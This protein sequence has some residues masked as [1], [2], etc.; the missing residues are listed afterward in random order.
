M[1][2]VIEN[3][4]FYDPEPEVENFPGLEKYLQISTQ[5]WKRKRVPFWVSFCK[6]FSRPGKFSTFGQGVIKRAF[7]ITRDINSYFVVCLFFVF[8]ILFSREVIILEPFLT[9][10]SLLRTLEIAMRVLIFIGLFLIQQVYLVE[11]KVTSQC[12]NPIW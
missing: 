9:T 1:S 10:F 11:I 6:Y 3:A 4:A 2:L 8:I 12:S 7:S 5:K